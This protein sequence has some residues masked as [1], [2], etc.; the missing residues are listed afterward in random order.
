M[1]VDPI[2]ELVCEESLLNLQSTDLDL[3]LIVINKERLPH[4]TSKFVFDTAAASH[5][6]CY[7]RLFSKF[8][9]CNFDVKG[10]TPPTLISQAKAM[11]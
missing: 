7:K 9:S 4:H 8:I 11:Y 5:I 6:A 10:E 2:I 3:H 1:D